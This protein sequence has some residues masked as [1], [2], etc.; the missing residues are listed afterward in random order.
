MK[1]QFLPAVAIVASL[2]VAGLFSSAVSA[3]SFDAVS[4]TITAKSELSTG[5]ANPVLDKVSYGI[6]SP[7]ETQALI[8]ALNGGACDGLILTGSMND[9]RGAIVGI[10]QV[11]SGDF[12]NNGNN[13]DDGASIVDAGFA[14]DLKAALAKTE[15]V[16]LAPTDGVAEVTTDDLNYINFITGYVGI[17]T[18]DFIVDMTAYNIDITKA[19]LTQIGFKVKMV[20]ASGKIIVVN[21]D[22]LNLLEDIIDDNDDGTLVTGEGVFDENGEQVAEAGFLVKNGVK[23]TPNTGVFGA[24]DSAATASILASLAVATA[25]GGVVVAVKKRLGDNEEEQQQ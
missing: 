12:N 4:C 8:D 25:A 15:E 10:Y 17:N 5:G 20:T 6:A 7:T 23:L 21:K 16:V 13:A 1:K 2:G 3:S 24:D 14:A 22:Q 9:I 19:D 11:L 18:A